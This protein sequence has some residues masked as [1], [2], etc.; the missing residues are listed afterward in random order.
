MYILLPDN[1]RSRNPSTNT[2]HDISNNTRN[3]AEV[4]NQENGGTLSQSSKQK[5][6]VSMKKW[7]VRQPF[8]EP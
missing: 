7:M 2:G 6:P 3:L 4:A 8:E 1:T 5:K